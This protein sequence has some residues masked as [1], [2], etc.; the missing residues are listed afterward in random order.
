MSGLGSFFGLGVMGNALQTFQEAADVTSDNIA[1]LNTP[2][3]S[4]QNANISEAPAVAGSPFAGAHFAG[5]Y[6]NGSIVSDIQRVHDDSYD[7]LFRGATA[8]G[9]FFTTQQNQLQ[10]LQAGLGEPNNGINA[11]YTSFQSAIAQLV[12]QA[13]TGATSARGNVLS[14]AQALTQALNN[15]ANTITQQKSQT[16]SQAA[17]IVTTVNGLLDQIAALNG[18]IRASTAVGDSPNTSL[19]QR[20]RLIDR[21]STYLSTQTSVQKDG[22]VLVTV[23]GQALVTDTVAYHLN[24]PVIGTA[25]NGT[26]VFKID[27]QSSAPAPASA[28][29]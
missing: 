13:G 23:G 11:Y 8:S 4:R 25:A 17:G 21:L 3:A 18:H 10:A 19:D 9:N 7:A 14:A 28:A 27:F 26:P 24:N 16:G 22:S 15:A 6:G 1:N 5:T 29:G 12:N 2:G 20:D